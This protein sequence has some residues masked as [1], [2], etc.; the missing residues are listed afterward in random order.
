M[1][2]NAETIINAID[3]AARTHYREGEA[4]RSDRLAYEVGALRSK[5]REVCRLLQLA[6]EE[7]EILKMELGENK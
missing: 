5:V 2:I 4:D 6:N 1:N 7:I 3:H